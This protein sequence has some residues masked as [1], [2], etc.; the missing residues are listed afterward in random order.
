MKIHRGL[1]AAAAA[2][3]LLATGCGSESSQPEQV[4]AAA[5]A[6][7]LAVASAERSS[8][9]DPVL[10][11]RDMRGLWEDHVAWT[12]LF[13][14]S[15]VA[16]LEDQDAT[17]KRLLQNQADI[18]EA[19]AAFYGEQAGAELT[20]LLR[21]HIL[22][23]ADII[24]AAKNDKKA[25]LDKRSAD[26]YAN[27]DDIAE[28]LAGANPAWLDGTLKDM[29]RGHLD[30]TLKEAT[31]QL[32]GKY[33][34]SVAEYNHIATHI[35]HMADTLATGII[36]QFPDKFA[37]P[38]APASEL[39]LNDA[40]RTLWEDHVAWTRLFIV[41][42]V[43][44]LEDKDATTKRLLQNQADIGEAVAAF[45]G[46]QAGVQLTSLLREHILIAADIVAAAKDDKKAQL[47]KR[48]A[49]WYTNADDIADFLADANPAWARDTLKDMMRG[50]L[51]QTLNEATAQL[52]GKY[53][54][55]VAEYDRIRTH[56]RQMADTLATG[57][58]TQFP[59]KF[60]A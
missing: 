10:F 54:A 5:A 38:T 25:Q 46:K 44:G 4:V 9:I 20:S 43:A 1:I 17:T 56:I 47:D 55:S 35:R 51:D 23:A 32:T 16:G 15:A 49:D 45:Y 11:R 52:T 57:I 42:A 26:W 58:T 39:A 19:V 14:V 22:I 13:I 7:T 41:S 50:H 12:R 21:E 36:T 48:S 31:A 30:Q 2:G 60:P 33:T 37:T 6:D 40:V 3:A 29:M 53:A 28:F 34:A 8:Q 18:G 59:D 27:A 24:A